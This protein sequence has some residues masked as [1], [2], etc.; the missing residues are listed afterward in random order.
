[1]RTFFWVSQLGMLPGTIVFVNAGKELGKIETAAG[2]LSPALLAS[3]VIL[4]L[5][6]IAVKK[7][8]GAVRKK[9]GIENGKI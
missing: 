3:F 6:P 9:V 1:L 5:F 8:M 7:I 2:I 4:G